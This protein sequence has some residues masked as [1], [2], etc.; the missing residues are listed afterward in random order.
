MS[1][2]Q[3]LPAYKASYDLWIEIFQ[4]TKDFSKEYKYKIG[5]CIDRAYL[6]SS[7]IFRAS[8]E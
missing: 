6:V 7:F 4:F 1:L 2:H 3:E 8:V 5:E